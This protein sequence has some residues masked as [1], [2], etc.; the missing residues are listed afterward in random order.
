MFLVLCGSGLGAGN[1]LPEVSW[2]STILLVSSLNPEDELSPVPRVVTKPLL[3]G[4][5]SVGA[6]HWNCLVEEK[7]LKQ[8]QHRLPLDKAV[9]IGP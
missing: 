2:V 3:D 8:L 1:K 6:E 9:S 4:Q 5:P 7:A